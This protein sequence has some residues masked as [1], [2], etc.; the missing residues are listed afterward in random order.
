[1][2]LVAM[3]ILPPCGRLGRRRWAICAG[4]AGF[5][6]TVGLAA[7]PWVPRASA[8]TTLT[9]GSGESTF[10]VPSDVTLL[11]IEAIGGWGG[12]RSG[13]TPAAPAEV[14]ATVRVCTSAPC[15]TNAPTPGGTLYVDVGSNGI[16]FFGAQF[17]G[18]AA[19]A[20]GGGGGGATFVATCSYVNNGS[21]K[22]SFN[23]AN[24]PR[25]IV[26]GGG[27]GE[28]ARGQAAKNQGA[29]TP[30]GA[31]SLTTG[32]CTSSG[33][34]GSTGPDATANNGN[35]LAGGG[36][37]GGGTCTSPGAGGVDAQNSTINGSAGDLRGGGGAGG[38]NHALCSSL[39]TIPGTGVT[40]GA[41]GGGG[42]G[43]QGG[44]GGAAANC[45]NGV[46]GAG[47]GGGGGSSFVTPAAT[48]VSSSA[49]SA[50]TNPVVTIT[51]TT[52]TAPAAT[53]SPTTV[54]FGTHS[55][56]TTSAAQTVT[57]TD[58]GS[59][60][61]SVTSAT[62]AG[63]NAADFHTSNDTCTGQTLG[64]GAKCMVDVAFGPS[65][66]GDESASLQ[67]ADN[68]SD[69]PQSVTLSGTGADNADLAVAMTG[70][71]KAKSGSMFAYQITVTNNGPTQAAQA[72]LRDALDPGT[73]LVTATS[74]CTGV[75]AGSS[76]TLTC[77]LGAV[78]AGGSV[79]V[80]VNVCVASATG[81]HL[82]NTATVADN[83]P[84]ASDP[85]P[86]NNSAT[87]STAVMN[88]AKRGGC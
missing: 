36:G 40:E 52:A 86:A 58:S 14:T 88:A 20:G 42:G 73:T 33:S 41:G 46:V 31:A 22:S 87:V 61:L 35:I 55:V 54:A 24:E 15:A 43:Y 1:M 59:A 63:T 9:F 17:G 85:N 83:A 21:C 65:L 78:A 13:D 23:T 53:P 10:V 5:L 49:P 69:S 45:G 82:T 16:L 18:G 39:F 74:G 60:P 34:A 50:N 32:G 26:A 28:G 44:G 77:T 19:S 6:L 27:G 47:G 67:F 68:A 30:G 3:S 84:G 64:V 2:G 57:L 7:M 75:A 72:T 25:L 76:G 80:T 51:Y 66:I 56:G 8:A 81:S 4:A 37:G 71:S 70:P 12:V 29:W 79:I 38:D 62:V 11:T 48:G